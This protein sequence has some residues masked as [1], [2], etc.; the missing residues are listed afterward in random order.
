MYALRDT[1]PTKLQSPEWRAKIQRGVTIRGAKFPSPAVRIGTGL[2]KKSLDYVIIFQCPALRI[3]PERGISHEWPQRPPTRSPP[4]TRDTNITVP[5]AHT[6]THVGGAKP[7]CR[8]AYQTGLPHSRGEL[9]EH[10]DY[11]HTASQSRPAGLADPRRRSWSVRNTGRHTPTAQHDRLLGLALPAHRCPSCRNRDKI[12]HKGAGV[13]SKR[14]IHSRRPL[15]SYRDVWA[16]RTSMMFDSRLAAG[17]APRPVAVADAAA[18]Y[19]TS[20]LL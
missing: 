15:A 7:P 13:W 17:V 14:L 11:D 6:L 8:G 4:I 2:R 5:A 1:Q 12:A 18:R 3:R 20:P 10:I 16:A 19:L 9:P